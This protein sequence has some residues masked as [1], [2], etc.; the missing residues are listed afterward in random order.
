LIIPDVNL[1]LYA[2]LDA[3]PVHA[4][5]K[6]WWEDALAGDREVGLAPVVVFGF[7]RIATN[8]RAFTVP[9]SIEDALRRVNGWRAQPN[10]TLLAAGSGHLDI[11]FRVLERLGAAGNLTT[12]V[13]IAAHAIEV[14]GE[15]F[16]NDGDFARIEGLRCVNPFAKR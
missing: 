9:L 11:A 8:R 7:L 15:V 4:K 6:R 5:A 16:S 10:V 13:Q 14:N 1:L 2:E 3:F 12:D